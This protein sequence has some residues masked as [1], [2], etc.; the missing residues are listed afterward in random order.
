MKPEYV[1][2]LALVERLHHRFLEVV[3]VELERMS[4]RGISNVQSLILL[5]MGDEELSAGELTTRGCYLS[6]NVSYN[7]KKLIDAGFVWQRNSPNDHRL[8]RVNLTE[9]GLA[10]RMR[11]EEAFERHAAV[12]DARGVSLPRLERMI[13]TLGA[14][15]RGRPRWR[16]PPR[17]DAPRA[18]ACEISSRQKRRLTPFLQA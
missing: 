1:E 18:G 4:E 9:Q 2:S 16:S 10:L 13:A 7:L 5:N 6:T 3:R 17:A 12:L 14:L 11:R 8:V 15:G